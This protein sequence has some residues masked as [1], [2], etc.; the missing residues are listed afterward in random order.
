MRHRINS[1]HC[2]VPPHILR[3][4]VENGSTEQRDWALRTLT[5]SA[6]TRGQREILGQLP[7]T[8]PAGTKL[9]SIY[10][11]QTGQQLPG[12][13]VRSEGDNPTG[14]AEVDESYDG[15]GAT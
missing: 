1:L 8:A 6:F 7:V 11:A 5:L 12:K 4:V 10:D 9:R 3:A 13:L 14:D 2:I 15:A